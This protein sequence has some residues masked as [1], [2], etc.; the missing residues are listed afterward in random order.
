M[1][2]FD[3]VLIASALKTTPD[4]SKVFFPWGIFG[5]GYYINSEEERRLQSYL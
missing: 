2:R 1:G 4:G 5:K 3:D